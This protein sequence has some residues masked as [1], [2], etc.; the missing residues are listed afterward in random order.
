MSQAND[1]IKIAVQGRIVWS[2]NPKSLF[3]GKEK[4]DSNGNI[5]KNEKGETMLEFGFGLAVPMPGPQS[6]PEARQNFETL[7]NS[8]H[9]AALA[10]Y[11]GAQQVPNGF[12]MKM[13]LPHEVDHRGQ[14]YSNRTGYAGCMVIACTTSLP[15]RFYKHQGPG[16]TQVNEGVKTGDYVQVTLEIKGHL[17]KPGTQ[18]KPGLYLNPNFVAYIQAGEEIVNG[19][20]IEEVLGNAPLAVPSWIPAPPANVAAPQ[21]PQGANSP[22]PGAPAPGGY[23]PAQQAAPYPGILPQHMQQQQ[24]GGAGFNQGPAAAPVPPQQGGYQQPAP[25]PA[26]APPMAQYPQGGGYPAPGVQQQQPVGGGY[27]QPG[28]PGHYG[29][30]PQGTP[31]PGAGMPPMPG[32]PGGYGQQ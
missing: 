30:A 6:S 24:M 10:M 2:S 17:P 4:K 18:G 31:Q 22:M 11:P 8:M 13:K 16:W 15:V 23:A 3:L 14:P 1:S 32:Y 19:P 5:R 25:G 28:V 12:S 29:N 21:F 7:W 9:Q 26:M 20:D 27:P